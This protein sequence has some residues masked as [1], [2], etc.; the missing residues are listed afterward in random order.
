MVAVASMYGHPKADI[1]KGSS[2][3]QTMYFN[4][5]AAIPYLTGG[6]TGSEALEEER[7]KAINAWKTMKDNARKKR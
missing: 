6:K 4:A 2:G 1:E 3:L 7:Q 5:M